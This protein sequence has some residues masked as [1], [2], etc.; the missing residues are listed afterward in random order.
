[1][2]SAGIGRVRRERLD[3]GA[4]VAVPGIVVDYLLKTDV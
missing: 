4:P 1:M 2:T 3:F